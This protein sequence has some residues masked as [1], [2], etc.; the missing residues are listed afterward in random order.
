M[1]TINFFLQKNEK[2]E[3]CL[4]L[5]DLARK[6]KV[7]NCLVTIGVKTSL[8]YQQFV[9]AC[10]GYAKMIQFRK[11][12]FLCPSCGPSP[13]YVVCDGK[14]DG[15]TK[16]KVEHLHELDSAEHDDSCLCQG[17]F[18]EDRVFLAEKSERA[19][20]CKLL[21]D[22]ILY[23]EFVESEAISSPN[24]NLV[25]ELVERL[26]LSWPEEIPK[27]YKRLLGNIC[28]ISS[29]AGFL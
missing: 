14:T 8:T 12:D 5:P 9:R 22:V 23:E 18:F 11:E 3:K 25:V 15:P 17:S 29:V 7:E 24:G 21:T 13:K 20:V 19:L 4:E 10:T 27:P 16:H 2:N 26:S 28:K 6:L 1:T